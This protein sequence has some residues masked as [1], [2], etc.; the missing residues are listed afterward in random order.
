MIKEE[1][2]KRK[3]HPKSSK[4]RDSFKRQKMFYNQGWK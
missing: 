3:V 1:K 2:K 4:F